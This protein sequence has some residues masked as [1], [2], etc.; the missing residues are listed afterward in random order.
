MYRI[1]IFSQDE[2]VVLNHAGATGLAK[3]SL[4]GG[5][6]LA[7]PVTRSNL[8]SAET[9]TEK[10]ESKWTQLYMCIIGENLFIILTY[11]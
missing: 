9:Q 10:K 7:A 1:K 8:V 3:A 2:G 5:A 6:V 4:D 11:N